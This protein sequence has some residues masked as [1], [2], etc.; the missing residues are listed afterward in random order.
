M[1]YVALYAG[2]FT[3]NIGHY[4]QVEIPNLESLDPS[5]RVG[6]D[7]VNHGKGKIVRTHDILKALNYLDTGYCGKVIKSY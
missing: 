5:I 1:D 3:R 6:I 2:G 4:T 7:L